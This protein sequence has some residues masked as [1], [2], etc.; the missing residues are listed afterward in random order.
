MQEG[1]GGREPGVEQGDLALDGVVGRHGIDRGAAVLAARQ[2]DIGVE[3]APREADGDAAEA[4][5]IE[6]RRADR[7][8]RPRLTPFLQHVARRRHRVGDEQILDCVGV[9][10]GA[11]QAEH[12]PIVDDPRVGAP[13]HETAIV[14]AAVAHVRRAVGVL[15]GAMRAH[16][17]RVAP[18]AGEAPGAAQPVAAVDSDRRAGAVARAPGEADAR[19]AE[20]GESR[21]V[22]HGGGRGRGGDVGLVDEPGGAGIRP[23]DGFHGLAEIDERQLLSAEAARQQQAQHV[24]GDEAVHDVRRE[25]AATVDLDTMPVEQRLQGAGPLG[26][27]EGRSV[28]SGSRLNAVHG[29]PRAMPVALILGRIGSPSIGQPRMRLPSEKSHAGGV[30]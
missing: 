19:A 29:S 23:G 17:G 14:G 9:A 11:A 30:V 27:A 4:A 22:R 5:G 26:S 7:V 1:A 21:F 25:L 24:L 10:A 6:E 13:E 18:A 12:E 2:V 8:D 16:P 15:Y 28:E 20:G 3:Q